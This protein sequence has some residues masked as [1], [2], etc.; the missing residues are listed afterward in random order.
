ML[1]NIVSSRT[2]FYFVS[3]FRKKNLNHAWKK[4]ASFLLHQIVKF[5]EQRMLR[6]ND[7]DLQQALILILHN[8]RYKIR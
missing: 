2:R 3:R 4:I 8:F 1:L 5:A 7:H 6:N